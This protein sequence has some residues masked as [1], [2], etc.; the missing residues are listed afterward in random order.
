[1]TLDR[2]CG[3]GER[4][5]PPGC[6]DCSDAVKPYTFR[7]AM[8]GLPTQSTMNPKPRSL[9]RSS[10]LL[11][12]RCRVVTSR[13]GEAALPPKTRSRPDL[14]PPH[15]SMLQ[16]HNGIKPGVDALEVTTLC[17]LKLRDVRLQLIDLCHAALASLSLLQHQ[18]RLARFCLSALE[19]MHVSERWYQLVTGEVD[20]I[21]RTGAN[22]SAKQKARR[23]DKHVPKKIKGRRER[24]L[25]ITLSDQLGTAEQPA[26]LALP[27][28]VA[29]CH[30]GDRA[31]DSAGTTRAVLGSIPHGLQ[32][33]DIMAIS[34]LTRTMVVM[35]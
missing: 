1:M 17:R 35:N 30:I 23:L 19:L 10:R 26:R 14:L 16:R 32:V 21:L 33:S 3:A 11:C 4:G 13:E 7:P 12:R 6:V 8:H 2:R 9:C 24:R 29:I 20:L 28:C 25:G 15:A 22:E 31:K 34:R 5:D 27:R 18:H